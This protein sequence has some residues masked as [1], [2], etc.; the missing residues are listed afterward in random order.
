MYLSSCND[1]HPKEKQ[2]KR[3]EKGKEVLMYE[4]VER[5]KKKGE[6]KDNKKERRYSYKNKKP[7]GISSSNVSKKSKVA[8]RPSFCSN[9]LLLAVT[10]FLKWRYDLSCVACDPFNPIV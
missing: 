7:F 4:V 3:G 9:D 10:G 5:D 1:Q 6:M 2:R 8:L